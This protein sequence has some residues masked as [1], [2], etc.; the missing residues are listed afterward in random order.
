MFRPFS[1]DSSGILR[2]PIPFIRILQYFAAVMTVIIILDSL[3]YDC[4]VVDSFL[5]FVVEWQRILSVSLQFLF[6]H[7]LFFLIAC[8]TLKNS[9]AKWQSPQLRIPETNHSLSDNWN[10][11]VPQFWIFHHTLFFFICSSLHL[12]LSCSV[13]QFHLIPLRPPSNFSIHSLSLP[14]HSV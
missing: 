1:G 14:T 11:L 4:S 10:P 9:L 7:W 12:C 3:L 5:S 2:I 6:N 8:L 13:A